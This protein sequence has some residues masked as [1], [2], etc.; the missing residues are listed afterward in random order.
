MVKLWAQSEAAAK[1]L[2]LGSSVPQSISKP[3]LRSMI[4]PVIKPDS[5][6]ARKRTTWANSSGSQKRPTGMSFSS[7][8]R[9]YSLSC[10]VIMGVLTYAGATALAVTPKGASSRASEKVSELIAPLETE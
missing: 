9:C 6:D 1:G 4:S 8:C 5:G 10:S 3:P 7:F 2:S